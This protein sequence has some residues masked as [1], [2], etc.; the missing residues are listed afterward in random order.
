MLQTLDLPVTITFQR[1][2]GGLLRINL[3][4]SDPGMLAVN[5][6]ETTSLDVDKKALRIQARG[7]VFLN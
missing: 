4:P 5:L 7:A 2:Q 6:T 3:Q 1:P